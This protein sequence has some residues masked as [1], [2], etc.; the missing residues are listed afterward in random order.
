MTDPTPKPEDFLAE[1]I[2]E[3]TF[4]KFLQLLAFDWKKEQAFEAENVSSPYSSGALGWENGTI[5][6]FLESAAACGID[7]LSKGGL[8]PNANPWRKAAAIIYAGKIYE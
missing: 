3:Q 6:Q 7:Q 8:G 5:G 1:V 4:L 2:D